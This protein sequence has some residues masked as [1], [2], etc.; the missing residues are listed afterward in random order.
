MAKTF[1]I[2]V[3][4][5]VCWYLLL[6]R[7]HLDAVSTNI[8]NIE[9][10]PGVSGFLPEVFLKSRNCD[11]KKYRSNGWFLSCTVIP[12]N[13]LF[14]YFFCVSI[15]FTSDLKPFLRLKGTKP[16]L[17]ILWSTHGNVNKLGKLSKTQD[18]ALFCDRKLMVTLRKRRHKFQ[19][20]MVIKLH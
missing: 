2:Q 16:K 11:N 9:V 13:A 6:C 18:K 10:A 5:L 17:T 12:V 14:F 19:L 8:G 1:F 7:S 20:E 15:C 4:N 3:Q